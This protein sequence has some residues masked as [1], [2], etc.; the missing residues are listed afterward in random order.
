MKQEGTVQ[1][2]NFNQR[3]FNKPG[4]AAYGSGSKRGLNSRNLKYND[5]KSPQL[6]NAKSESKQDSS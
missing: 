5:M 3:I 6:K 2:A 1:I 4:S